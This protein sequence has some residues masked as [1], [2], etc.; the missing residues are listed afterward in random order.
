MATDSPSQS[1][2]PR[3]WTAQTVASLAAPREYSCVGGPFGSDLTTKDY[4]D[5]GVPVIRGAN[6]TRPGLWLDESEFVYV[7]EAKADSL[8]RNL[9]YPGDLVFTQRGTLGQVARISPT[10]AYRRFLL[11]QSQ[12]K[13]AVDDSKADPIMSASSSSPVLVSDW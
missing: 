6:L 13:L 4:V 8:S 3:A 12:M 2:L 7:T 10:T 9:A 1:S 11:S 5:M